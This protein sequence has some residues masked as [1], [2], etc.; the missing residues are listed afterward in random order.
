MATL[1]IAIHS[2]IAIIFRKHPR[3]VLVPLLIV[4]FIWS[5]VIC[6]VVI[7]AVRRGNWNLPDPYWCWI[8]HRH[9]AAQLAGEYVWLWTAGLA[10]IILYVP[11]FI[12]L[13]GLIK[14]KS[15]RCRHFNEIGFLSH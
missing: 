14:W 4:A 9:L 8:G 5:Y 1:V 13:Q 7:I 11:L 2:F 3:G 12:I 6:F 15:K 10:S